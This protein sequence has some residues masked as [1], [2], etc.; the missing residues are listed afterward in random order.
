VTSVD[1]ELAKG[2]LKRI[3]EPDGRVVL[4]ARADDDVKAGNGDAR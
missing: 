1:W 2:L 4:D 3:V